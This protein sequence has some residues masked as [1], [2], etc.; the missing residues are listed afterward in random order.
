MGAHQKFYKLNFTAPKADE[1]A[2]YSGMPEDLLPTKLV[3]W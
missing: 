1:C 3:R 2:I